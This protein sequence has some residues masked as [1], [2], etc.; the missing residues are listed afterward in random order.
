VF[1]GEGGSDG[2]GGTVDGS[3]SPVSC[4]V[5]VGVLVVVA[6]VVGDG[7]PSWPPPAVQPESAARTTLASATPIAADPRA[8]M[9]PDT[10]RAVP[11]GAVPERFFLTWV[12]R[13]LYGTERLQELGSA[14]RVRRRAAPSMTDRAAD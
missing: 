12:I 10:P 8:R 3:D 13:S 14:R 9:A 1:F 6:A 2:K 5:T 11:V 7:G 4:V